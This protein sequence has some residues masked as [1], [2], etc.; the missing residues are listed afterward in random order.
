[1]AKVKI[2]GHASGTGILTVTA[3][4]TSTDR[5]ITLPDATGTLLNSDGSAASLTSIPAANITGTLPAIDGSNLTGIAGRRNMIINGDMKV[6]QRG[7]SWAAIA[8]DS[9]S[10]DRWKFY[11]NLGAYTVTQDSTGADGFANS[12]KIDCTTADA[13]VVADDYLLLRYTFEGQDLQC[14]KKGTASA[15]SVTLSFWVKSNKTGDLAIHLFDADN[16]RGIGSTPTINSADTWEKKTITFAGDTT[17]AFNDDNVDS[18]WLDFW[19]DGGSTYTGGSTPTSWEAVA[20]NDRAAGTTL[21]LADSTSNYLNI[22]GIQL[23]LGTAA[24]NFE[25]RSYAEELALCQRYYYRF[26]ESASTLLFGGYAVDT[27]T[28]YLPW[29][30]PVTMR[31]APTM[32]K[33]GTWTVGLIGQPTAIYQHPNGF[34][35]SITLTSTGNWYFHCNGSDDYVEASA[36]M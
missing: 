25:H 7:T 36:E 23:E 32:T 17:G 29:E 26:G 13:S 6:S 28:M 34:S 11:H 22:T 12:F 21:A 24:T 31:T 18:L 33:N 4:N 3:P 9:Y 5:T 8:S 35:F 10:L 27:N 1:M 14:W 2:Q 20:H 16:T 19:F 15:E 30:F